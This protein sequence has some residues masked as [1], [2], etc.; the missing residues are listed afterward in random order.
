VSDLDAKLV[1][2]RD[3]LWRSGPDVV[4]IRRVDDPDDRILEIAGGA[5]LLWLALGDTATV[6]ELAAAFGVRVAEI[7]QALGLMREH[8]LVMPA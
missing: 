3:V 6:D 5:R 7:D 2:A 8:N 1:R 4:L